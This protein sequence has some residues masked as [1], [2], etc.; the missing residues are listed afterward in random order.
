MIQSSKDHE[1]KLVYC[2]FQICILTSL[3]LTCQLLR[4]MIKSPFIIITDKL[5][6]SFWHLPLFILRLCSCYDFVGSRFCS[7]PANLILLSYCD[8]FLY[9]SYLSFLKNIKPTL[10]INVGTPAFFWLALCWWTFGI[11]SFSVLC[12]YS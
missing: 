6:S 11:P 2:T 3:C 12:S 7:L 1:T 8:A 5:T 9:L 4:E 10:I